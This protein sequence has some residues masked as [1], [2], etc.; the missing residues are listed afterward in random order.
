MRLKQ[1][2]LLPIIVVLSIGCAK[3]KP[4]PQP[5]FLQGTYTGPFMLIHMHKNSTKPDTSKATVLL[6][7][8]ANSS[9]QV[10]GDTSTLHAG[11]HGTF[12]INSGTIIQFFDQTYPFTGTPAKIHLSG[13]YQ[14]TYDNVV[15]R[16]NGNDPADT[17]LYQYVLQKIY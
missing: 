13:T 2:Y 14:F 4:A 1:L 7:M 6:S 15:L 11:S 9:Y 12:V 17:V 5:S 8:Q 16:L 3:Q 10:S